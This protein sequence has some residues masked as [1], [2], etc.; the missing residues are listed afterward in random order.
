MSSP[1]RVS[2]RL[3]LITDR[4]VVRSGDLVSAC[5][6]ALTAA[7]EAAP[8]GTVALQLREKD[9][10]A[11]ALYELALRLRAI[12]S[13]AGAPLIVNDRVDV[14]IAADADGVHLPSDSIGVSMAR[15]LLGPKRLI[16]VSTH[17]PPDVAGAARE[18]A[19][20]AVFGPVFDPLSKP[21]AGS[22]WGASGLRAAC[23]AGAIPVFAL[24]GITPDRTRELFA[25]ADP[26][27]R[28]AGV[29]SIGAIFAAE[30]PALATVAMLS[31]LDP[32]WTRRQ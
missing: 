3:Y 27:A 31:A 24:G 10:S 21:A 13:R 29:A 16:G 30:S 14:A 6:A 17:S 23:A 7:R 32:S 15:T 4:R 2:F 18:G 19:D 12:C 26:A 22:A 28:P 11:R 5:E 1:P 9:L 8:P 20:F 25:S